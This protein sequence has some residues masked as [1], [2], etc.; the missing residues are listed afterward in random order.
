MENRRMD[1]NNMNLVEF[2]HHDLGWHKSGYKEEADFTNDEIN[3][4]LDIM[5]EDETYKFCW[6]HEHVVFI[7]QYIQ[8]H[9][10]RFEEL[11]QRILEGRFEIGAGYSSPY[12][13]FVTAEILVRQMIY[14]KKWV[15]DTFEGYTSN[16]FYNTDVPGMTM[17]L[18]QILKKSGVEYLYLS[19]SWSFENFRSNEFLTWYAPDGTGMPTH[20]MNHYGDNIW[21]TKNIAFV[22]KR[23][24]EYNYKNPILLLAM[25]CTPPDDLSGLLADWEQY[26][27]LNENQTKNLPTLKYSTYQNAIK[28]IFDNN[29]FM[30][31]LKGEWPNKWLYENIASDHNCFLDQR[32]AERKLRYAEILGV[33]LG[34]ARKSFDKYDIEKFEKAWRNTIHSCHGFAPAKP[35]EDFRRIYGEAHEVANTLLEEQMQILADGI[36]SKREGI[37]LV[38]F[39]TS[40]RTR[41]DTVT[42]NLPEGIEHAVVHNSKGDL[43]PS[44]C[45]GLG[46]ITI[47]TEIPSVGFTTVYLSEAEASKQE[48]NLDTKFENQFYSVTLG[49]HGFTSVYD[50][51]EKRELFANGKF[52]AGELLEMKYNGCGAGEHKHLWQPD[53]SAYQH[54]FQENEL[55]WNCVEKGNVKTVFEAKVETEFA[56]VRIQVTAYE[57]SKKL[58]Y[59]VS[60]SELNLK[61]KQQLRVMFPTKAGEVRYEVPFAEVVVSKD[62]VLKK[63]SKFNPNEGRFDEDKHEDNEGVRPREVQNYISCKSEEGETM[64]SSYNL[65]WD[66]QDPTANPIVTPVL[67]AIL[68][69]ASKSCHWEYGHWLQADDR[70]Y[71]FSIFSGEEHAVLAQ[72]ATENNEVVCASYS[73]ACGDLFQTDNYSLL[74][75]ADPNLVLTTVKK[76]EDDDKSYVLRAFN[77]GNKA[78]TESVLLGHEVEKVSSVNML[79][80]DLKDQR[81]DLELKLD[82][83]QIETYRIQPIN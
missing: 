33:I 23:V 72:K 6:T 46:E 56:K 26:R 47:E 8:D 25:D 43:I 22:E 15:E 73:K 65:A 69:S 70:T 51:E 57:H 36:T 41:R 66:Y 78:V 42:V 68:L 67:Q 12:T 14:G 28:D 75:F 71:H 63:F 19:R 53:S 62:E 54:V 44:Q 48:L 59:D 74:E 10:E 55:T 50:K 82:P 45:N 9:S 83:A 40:A 64:I 79:E 58:S 34:L 11:K 30:N 5:K 38:L 18:P 4:A 24:P 49:K 16:V 52:I 80:K 77:R 61:E 60:F 81:E 32:E 76:A 1:R 20:F 7:Y 39:Q 21:E 37:P 17:Q 29:E 27:N 3:K 2:S 13:S 31:T 35:I